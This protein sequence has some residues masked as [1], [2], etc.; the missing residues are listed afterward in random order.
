MKLGM[1]ST[2][3]NDFIRNGIVGKFSFF[4]FP[5]LI[6]EVADFKGFIEGSFNDGNNL[7]VG[8]TKPQQVKF[9]LDSTGC[10]VMK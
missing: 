10:L 7:L 6:E 2:S 9:Y 3:M 1:D 5:H 8:H 4:N